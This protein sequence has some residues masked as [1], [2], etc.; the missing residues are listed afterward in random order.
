MSRVAEGAMLAAL[1]ALEPEAKA[2]WEAEE[3]NLPEAIQLSNAITQRRVADA[4]E[5]VQVA[6]QDT[7]TVALK[8]MDPTLYADLPTTV[9]GRYTITGAEEV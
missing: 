7:V 6:S 5:A 3:C 2:A 4:Q 9:R 1:D 8:E